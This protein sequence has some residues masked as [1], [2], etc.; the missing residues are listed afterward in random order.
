MAYAAAILALIFIVVMVHAA[1]WVGVHYI[2]AVLGTAILAF[3]ALALHNKRQMAKIHE[4]END[5]IGS[6]RRI[7]RAMNWP[8]ECRYCGSTIHSWRAARVHGDP[9]TSACAARWAELEAPRRDEAEPEAAPAAE[10]TR[11]ITTVKTRGGGHG[12]IDT[13]GEAT[14][15]PELE[16]EG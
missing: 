1:T 13:L 4:L 2:I 16:Q 8:K 14:D 9:D 7:N 5:V 15:R 3:T 6:Y 11:W 10:Q 12:S